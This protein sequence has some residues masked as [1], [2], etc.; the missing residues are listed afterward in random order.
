MVFRSYCSVG[1]VQEW[2]DGF[3]GRDVRP[4]SGIGARR[5]LC[6]AVKDE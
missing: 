4:N 2:R 5:L 3:V 1:Q 6:P